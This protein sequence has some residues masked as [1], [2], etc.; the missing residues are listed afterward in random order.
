MTPRVASPPSTLTE[1]AT[2]ELA[3]LDVKHAA[4][5]LSD[6]ERW[7]RVEK[8]TRGPFACMRQ[9]AYTPAAVEVAEAT[10]TTT[11]TKPEASL[12]FEAV[13]SPVEEISSSVPAT[14]PALTDVDEL[15]GLID[16]QLL[17]D[18]RRRLEAQLLAGNGT[19]PN[20][21]GF[22]NTTVCS[23]GEGCGNRGRAAPERLDGRDRP[24]DHGTRPLSLHPAP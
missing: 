5:D 1:D 22:D 20:L 3:K 18:A 19:S 4:G 21:R 8:R 13:S 2:L 16:E 17:F 9:T 14:T 10:S 23:P 11:G 7:R 24:A 6:A 12:P 15:R